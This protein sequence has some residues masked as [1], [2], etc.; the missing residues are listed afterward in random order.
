MTRPPPAPLH[1]FLGKE[2]GGLAV[3]CALLA[4]ALGMA[5]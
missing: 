3:L 1:D 2:V 4:V 5:F